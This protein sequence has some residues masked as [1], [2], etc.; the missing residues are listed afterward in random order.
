MRRT[1]ILLTLLAFAGS[2]LIGINSAE[3]RYWHNKSG[4][5]NAKK[6]EAPEAKKPK[7][8]P[9]GEVAKGLTKVPGLF[10][11]YV[12]KDENKVLMAVKKDQFEKIFLCNM[13]RSAGDGS[14]FDAGA[15]TGSFP[16]ELQ[17]VG[18]QLQLLMVLVQIQKMVFG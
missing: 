13:T 6:A 10:D 18:E 2:M 17:R 1:M 9:F 5:S 4:K 11:F 14:F 15:Q 16:F 12:D 8:K 7:L 3:A